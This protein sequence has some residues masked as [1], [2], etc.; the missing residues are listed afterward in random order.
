VPI[1]GNSRFNQ[2]FQKNLV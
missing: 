2:K 1:F